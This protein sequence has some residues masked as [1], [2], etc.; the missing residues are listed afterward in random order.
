MA[1][2]AFLLWNLAPFFVMCDPSN[3]GMHSEIDSDLAEGNPII[4]LFDM[5]PGGIGLSKK[6]Y[7]IQD[8]VLKAALEQVTE[9][10]CESGCPSCVGPVSENG[11][12]AKA[13]AKA[14]LEELIVT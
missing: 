8:K 11:E 4:A 6:I 12:G 9:C 3:L 10:K 1:G 7:Q 14:I 13:H 5:I 2:L